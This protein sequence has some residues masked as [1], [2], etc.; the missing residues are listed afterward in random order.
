MDKQLR[1]IFRNRYFTDRDTGQL[2]HIYLGDEAVEEIISTSYDHLAGL[3]SMEKTPM[4]KEPTEAEFE[5]WSIR[6]QQVYIVKVTVAQS[7]NQLRQQI[8]KEFKGEK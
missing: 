1:K 8:L 4:P 2:R 3:P 5:S 7:M 6:N